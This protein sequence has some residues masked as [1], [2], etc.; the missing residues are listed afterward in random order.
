MTTLHVNCTGGEY[1]IVVDAGA[2]SALGDEIAARLPGRRVLLIADSNVVET[3][4]VVAGAS[5]G[6]SGF[7]VVT[8]VL[9]SDETLKTMPQVESIWA[10]A[11]DAGLDRSSCMVA[12]GG[13]LAGDVAGFA[14]S[15]FLRG[16]DFVQVPTTLL[17]MVDASV[18]GKT[19][20]N[21]R[22]P[23]GG[24]GKNLAGAFWQ[25]RLVLAD[26]N[27]LS[28]L[29][30]RE[31]R[32]G[33]AETIKHALIGAPELLDVI[34][35]GLDAILAADPV[36]VAGLVERAVKVKI[37]VVEKDERE[38]GMRAVLNLGH[39]FAHVIEP[40]PELNLKHG[41]AV[42]I[43][44]IAAAALAQA[45]GCL[46]GDW[47]ARLAELLDRAELPTR[48]PAARDP[49]KLLSRMRFDKKNQGGRHRLVVPIAPGQ[50][51]IMDDVPE[52]SI[53]QA[54][55]AVTG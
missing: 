28:T 31:R 45:L 27:T 46:E 52:A 30:V 55:Q 29:P 5:L 25:P 42:S 50:V 8:H 13:G 35:T 14:A 32:C 40:D 6:D 34:D 17:A 51:R 47:P 10:S 7:D 53:I 11:L 37:D 15:S 44:L 54:W 21:L 23:D 33:L 16:I 18:G 9:E 38:Q 41:E 43:G 22:L 20:I 4:A 24:L 2:L 36:A 3:H 12:I 19:G 1:D 26:P 49:E 48:L 39:T